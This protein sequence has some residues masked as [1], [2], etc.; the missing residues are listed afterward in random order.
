MV[1]GVKMS[2]EEEV[3]Y[4]EDAKYDEWAVNRMV[5]KCPTCGSRMDWS[6]DNGDY[7]FYC[8]RRG[9]G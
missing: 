8:R 1:W 7:C 5:P 3:G 2:E 6:D 4:D 9:E